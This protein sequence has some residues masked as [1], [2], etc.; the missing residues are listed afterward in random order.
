MIFHSESKMG[1]TNNA[2][3]TLVS[4][5]DSKWSKATGHRLCSYLFVENAL[6]Q[7]LGLFGLAGFEEAKPLVG[8][9]QL[10]IWF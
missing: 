10:N 9:N 1:S 4:L 3:H 6:L 7:G 5:A 2:V 8:G